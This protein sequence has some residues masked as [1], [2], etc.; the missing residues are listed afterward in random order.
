MKYGIY[1]SLLNKFTKFIP[2]R[3][4]KEVK[5]KW[6]DGEIKRLTRETKIAYQIKKTNSS[7]ENLQV[8]IQ[9]T[10]GKQ[11]SGNQEK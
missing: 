1:L 6:M 7:E 10:F 11:E 4:N 5:P 9:A 3:N 2:V 8:E